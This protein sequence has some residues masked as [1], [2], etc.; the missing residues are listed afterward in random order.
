MSDRIEVR[1]LRLRA[2]IGVDEE[3]RLG[4]QDVIVHLRCELDVRPAAHTDDVQDTA[5]YRTISERVA[6]YVESSRFRLIERLATE[7]ARVVL[8]TDRRIESV[9][10][11]VEKP[12]ALRRAD[13]VSIELERRRGEV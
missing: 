8:D 6:S 13:G 2:V 7:I 5:N 11:R 9:S 1:A 12:H 4:P 10:V 3:E